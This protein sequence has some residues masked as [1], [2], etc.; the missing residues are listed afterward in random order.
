MPSDPFKFKQTKEISRKDI[1]L[2]VAREPESNRLFV[3]SS[4]SNVYLIDPAAEKTEPLAL[5]GHSGYV[6]GVTVA[7]GFVV[8]GAYD[9][10]LIWRDRKSLKTE[11]THKAHERWIR[12][13][14]ASPDGKYIASVADDMVCRVWDV[15]SGKMKHELR[16]H[17]SMTPSHFNSMLYAC[18][19]SN[20][21][22]HLATGD[23]VGHIVVW[24]M[25]SG[26]PVKTIESPGMYTWDPR[27]RIHSIG[28]IRSLAFSPDNSVL[29]VGGM[30]KVGNIDHLEG[31][32]RLELFDWRA[33]KSIKVVEC[34]KIKGLI[35]R[36]AFHP[37]G[38][39]LVGAGGDSKGGLVFF[40]AAGTKTLREE[41]V[42]MHV[43][44]FTA[45]DS[46]DRLY[47]AGHNKLSIWEL[48]V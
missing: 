12:A 20:D 40:D 28:G 13:V 21:G 36:L 42:P 25:S 45:T 48:S 7:G 23:K 46:M 1:L 34:D 29:A 10:K 9:G 35:T 41:S 33:A 31:K 15:A 38:D 47:L 14:E 4:D 43:H 39:W 3:G 17:E 2:S 32:A 22:A 8:S 16:G 27:A 37:K 5:D 19:F 24:D 26:K 6:T 44:K 18:A 30:G 11:R